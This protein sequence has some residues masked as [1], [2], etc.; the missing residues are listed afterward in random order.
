MQ[1]PVLS[2]CYTIPRCYR[3]GFGVTNMILVSHV[4]YIKTF[5]WIAECT[6]LACARASVRLLSNTRVSNNICSFS[7][8]LNTVLNTAFHLLPFVY[9]YCSS[10]APIAID[11]FCPTNTILL[12]GHD[13]A[14]QAVLEALC[15]CWIILLILMEYLPTFRMGSNEWTMS[16]GLFHVTTQ[17]SKGKVA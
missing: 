3:D 11:C 17:L 13:C 7:C 10:S 14:P 16:L 2:F 12:K 8:S 5:W 4:E 15:W 9:N 6:L 1:A